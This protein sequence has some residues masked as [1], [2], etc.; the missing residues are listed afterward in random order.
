MSSR[1][2][3]L[4][5]ENMAREITALSPTTTRTVVHR[6]QPILSFTAE[7][8]TSRMEISEVK[9][10]RT[11]EPKKSTPISAPI[12]ASEM[13]AGNAMNARPMPDSTTSAICTPLAC[14]MKPRAEKTPMPARISKP[15]L[16]KPTTRPEPVRL[17]RF[18]R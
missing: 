7:T 8:T 9:P 3:P 15:E 13:M 5:V 6:P 11:R 17:V 2:S 4:V 14:A 10:A 16:E 18:F 12:G 1:F